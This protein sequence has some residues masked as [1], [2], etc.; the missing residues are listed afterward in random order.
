MKKKTILGVIFTIVIAVGTTVTAYAAPAGQEAIY[1]QKEQAPSVFRVERKLSAEKSS[2]ETSGEDSEK[3]EGET[4]V[5][6][7]VVKKAE[8]TAAEAYSSVDGGVL[9]LPKWGVS[10]S[11]SYSLEQADVDKENAGAIYDFS[12]LPGDP[13]GSAVVGDHNYQSGKFFAQLGV[14]DEVWVDAPYGQFSFL[15]ES[16]KVGTRDRTTAFRSDKG[17]LKRRDA[18]VDHKYGGLADDIWFADGSRLY[19]GLDT[20]GNGDLYLVTCWPLDAIVT[21]QLYVV[22]CVPN[23]GTVFFD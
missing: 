12:T 9:T 8:T 5:P 18:H 21:E 14:G 15:V 19:K 23:E 1:P 2:L 22:R 4:E 16:A 3:A 11:L 10:I 17:F 20:D 6:A 7:F 13:T